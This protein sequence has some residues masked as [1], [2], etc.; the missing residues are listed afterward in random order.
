MLIRVTT[1]VFI[2]LAPHFAV[3]GPVYSHDEAGNAKDG[4]LADL[5]Q[6][7]QRGESITVSY[8]SGGITWYRACPSV[9]IYGGVVSCYIQEVLDTTD[10]GGA[11]T[12]DSPRAIEAHI[13][14]TTGYRAAI[15][16]NFFDGS[17]LGVSPPERQQ[18]LSWF[19]N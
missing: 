10:G 6:A 16:K 17:E 15:K 8:T 2:A 7:V 4:S 1:A 19:A 12:F 5:R 13:Y 3:A 9:S 11:R 18:A 14:D